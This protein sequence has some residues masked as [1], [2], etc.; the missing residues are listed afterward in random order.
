MR[1]STTKRVWMAAVAL[2]VSGALGAC[3]DQPMGPT[4]ESYEVLMDETTTQAESNDCIVIDGQLFCK[5]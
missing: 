4:E 5:S 2:M 3:A 1:N